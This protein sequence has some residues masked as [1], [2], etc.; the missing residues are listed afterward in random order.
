MSLWLTTTYRLIASHDAAQQDGPGILNM[1]AS[2]I[3]GGEIA[4][5]KAFDQ[6]RLAAAVA[7]D[8]SAVP[9]NAGCDVV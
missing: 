4:T 3:F 7:G 8:A 6:H 9:W 5:E 1:E 2:T